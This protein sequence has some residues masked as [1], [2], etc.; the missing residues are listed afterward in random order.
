MVRDS[1]KGALVAA[2]F[3]KVRLVYGSLE[4][5]ALLEE[6]SS[7]A[8]IVIRKVLHP[9]CCVNA[10]SDQLYRYCRCI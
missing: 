3:P 10:N 5:T 4:D 1:N 7:K 6:E 2:S 9:D 8:D